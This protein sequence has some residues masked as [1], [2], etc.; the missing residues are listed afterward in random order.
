MST[1]TVRAVWFFLIIFVPLVFYLSAKLKT[2]WII[3]QWPC[4]C[5]STCIRHTIINPI[6]KWTRFNEDK[7]F[8]LNHFRFIKEKLHYISIMRNF[9]FFVSHGIFIDEIRFKKCTMFLRCKIHLKTKKRLMPIEKWEEHLEFC[10]TCNI[11]RFCV[12][13]FS[14]LRKKLY[15]F[16]ILLTIYALK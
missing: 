12:I 14:L 7:I 15:E 9:F 2:R 4:V 3:F 1:Y 8:F 6:N 13:L 11:W 5:Q 16:Q 10:F